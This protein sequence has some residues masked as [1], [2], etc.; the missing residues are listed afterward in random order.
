MFDFHSRPVEPFPGCNKICTQN[1][2]V[3]LY[4]YAVSDLI[5]SSINFAIEWE[6]AQKN[7]SS[8]LEGN[9]EEYQNWLY[10]TIGVC[11][12]TG[13]VL[14]TNSKNQDALKRAELCFAQHMLDSELNEIHK[15]KLEYMLR[16]VGLEEDEKT[17]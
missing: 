7:Y 6:D 12:R 3:C 13:E 2:P 11:Q 14:V 17:E 15:K 9:E 16:A 10:K 5:S 1:P 4:R 8:N